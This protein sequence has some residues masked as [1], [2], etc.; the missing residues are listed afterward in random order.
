MRQ[1]CTTCACCGRKEYHD[2]DSLDAMSL[3]CPGCGTCFS[4]ELPSTPLVAAP[5]LWVNVDQ[6]VSFGD[7]VDG[8]GKYLPAR[9][10][11]EG[12]FNLPLYA[13]PSFPPIV[14]AP[15]ISPECPQKEIPEKHSHYFKRVPA[16]VTHIDVYLV[17]ALFEQNDPAIAHAVKKLLCPGM[18]GAKDADKDLQEA[19]DSLKRSQDI[20]ESLR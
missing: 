1:V 7:A 10:T 19:I 6:L 5:A 3:T 9:K 11:Q 16:H 14:R 12:V 17:L 18:R 15:S 20:R 4:E 8:H 13:G 2:A